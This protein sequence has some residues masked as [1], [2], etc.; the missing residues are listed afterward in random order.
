MRDCL[1]CNWLSFSVRSFPFA[2]FSPVLAGPW[3]RNIM[4]R[5]AGRIQPDALLPQPVYL[6]PKNDDVFTRF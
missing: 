6:E 2:G 3:G 1:P 5:F 4:T